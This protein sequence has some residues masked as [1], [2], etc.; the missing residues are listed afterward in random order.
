[1]SEHRSTEILVLAPRGRDAELTEAVLGR[2][3][4]T[5]RHIDGR[6]LI[7]NLDAGVGAAV[8]TREALDSVRGPLT[9]WLAAQPPWSDFPL[10]VLGSAR[11]L[12]P[13][14]VAGLGNVTVLERPLAAATLLASVQAA[15]RARNRQYEA[16]A[17]IVQRDQ[18]LA[19]LGHELRNP[20]AAIVLGSELARTG[21]RDREQLASR[22]EMISRQANHL[23]RL[24]DDL[25][26]VARVTTGK[27][28]L[29][30]EAVDID[31]T[32]RACIETLAD[33]AQASGITLMFAAASGAVIA[34]DRLRLEQVVTNLLANAIK[35]SP[36]GRTVTV[37]S[38]LVDSTCEIRVRDQGIGI[39]EGML[40]HVFELFAQADS[41]LDRADGGMGIGLT[42]VDR[43][44]RLHG[45]TVTVQSAGLGL[46][47]EFV[48]RLP[49]G[50][51][52]ETSGI[53]RLPAAGDERPL[54]VIQVED[55][56]DIRDLM[57]SL[58]EQL[59]CTVEVAADG[60]EGVDRIVR[61]LPDL[62][63]IDI[64]LPGIDGFEVARRIRSATNHRVLLVAVTG[65]G[66][67]QD[68]D[69][70]L[71]AGFDR[72]VTKPIHAET[73]T[74]L[75]DEARRWRDASR[76]AAG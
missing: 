39:A 16:R 35:Y 40:P 34:G 47:S 58:L 76:A 19:M 2:S 26:D 4:V 57:S 12:A 36:G 73:L 69:R 1:V 56:A 13:L 7:A 32:I 55:N 48:V 70:A 75:L 18:F 61:S 45:G 72:H 66:R 11:P 60:L 44:V 14:K 6:D 33:R 22:L 28:R 41:S 64:G 74:T 67:S 51:A 63:L 71:A 46:G 27:V 3:G 42:L 50:A 65:Y 25:L 9:A 30:R 15:L 37:S 21:S 29:Q 43:L 54:R 17:A 62:A 68:R 49:A 20:L 8:V 23:A 10:I 24:V 5:A 53:I 52:P 38:A 59:G 31:D